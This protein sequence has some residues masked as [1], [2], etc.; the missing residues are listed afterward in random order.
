MPLIDDIYLNT[1]SAIVAANISSAVNV[2]TGANVGSYFTGIGPVGRVYTYDIVPVTLNTAAYG[3]LQTPGTGAIVLAAVSAVTTAT[4]IGGA[5]AIAADVPRVVTISSGGN[6][7]GITFT[8]NG[9]DYYGA[10]MTQTVT[11]VSAATVSTTKAF[12][13]VRSVSHTGTVASTV[14]VGTGDAYGLPFFLK[15]RGYIVSVGWAGTAAVTATSATVGVT[16]S[17]ATAFTGDVRGTYQTPSASNGTNRL[18][19]TAV[20][21]SG[22]VGT[23]ATTAAVLGVTQV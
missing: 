19:F 11:G 9:N 15:D 4:T 10:T 18:V 16:T 13:A 23:A 12:Y 17:P 22:Q 8:V 20:V 3:V 21:G 1:G 5:T 6:D 14:T 2:G 7:T